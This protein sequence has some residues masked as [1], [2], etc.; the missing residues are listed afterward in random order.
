[1]VN[2][3]RFIIG[4]V[5]LHTGYISF[6]QSTGV[7]KLSPKFSHLERSK[8]HP[9]D[10]NLISLDFDLGLPMTDSLVGLE[11]V[12]LDKDGKALYSKIGRINNVSNIKTLVLSSGETYNVSK[13]GQVKFTII[14][15]ADKYRKS[16][17][18]TLILQDQKGAK[19]KE[20]YLTR[21]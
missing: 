19:S 8:T 4:F 20:H 16:I 15:P 7:S 1:M 10:T 12:F 9:L 5:L 21:K 3:K 17:R 18:R 14:I 11:I 13:E 6:S 2:L